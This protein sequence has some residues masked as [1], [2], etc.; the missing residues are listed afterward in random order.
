MNTGTF[1]IDVMDKFVMHKVLNVSV[2]QDAISQRFTCP[3]ADGNRYCRIYDKL[4]RV[5]QQ[6]DKLFDFSLN[7]DHFVCKISKWGNMMELTNVINFIARESQPEVVTSIVNNQEHIVM[8]C[9][10]FNSE[11]VSQCRAEAP[12]K[13]RQFLIMDG[14]LADSYSAFDTK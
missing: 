2:S 12:G 9:Q 14:L 1:T 4:G 11:R 8:T 3:D 7:N 13:E 5:Y 10:I 6:C